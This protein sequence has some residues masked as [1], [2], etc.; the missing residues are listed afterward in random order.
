MNAAVQPDLIPESI[1]RHYSKEL[2]ASP[3]A[4]TSF[5]LPDKLAVSA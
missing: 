1:S 4:R 5:C 2:L 3:S